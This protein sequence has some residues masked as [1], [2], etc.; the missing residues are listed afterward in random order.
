MPFVGPATPL[1]GRRACPEPRA[2]SGGVERVRD[3]REANGLDLDV[4][5]VRERGA[6]GGPAESARSAA[7]AA[8]SAA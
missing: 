2:P 7:R 4:V 5:L 8:D 6:R 3:R 1:I